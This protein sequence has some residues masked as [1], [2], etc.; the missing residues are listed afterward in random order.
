MK[1]MTMI[2]TDLVI[3]SLLSSV[4]NLFTN[5]KQESGFQQFVGLVARNIFIFCI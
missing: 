1:M 4:F 5:Q 2:P 3:N